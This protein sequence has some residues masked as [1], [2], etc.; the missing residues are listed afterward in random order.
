M[1]VVNI[2][3]TFYSNDFQFA[4]LH[5]GASYAGGLVFD[6]DNSGNGFV[7]AVSD[8]IQSPWFYASSVCAGYSDG[9]Y[10]D[11]YLPSK[12]KLNQMYKNLHLNG[13]GGFTS[14]YFYWS[15]AAYDSN[16]AWVQGFTNDMQ[17][18]SSIQIY[19][20][21]RAIRAFQ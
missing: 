5:Y 13:L 17:Y 2:Y 4:N 14:S 7:A 10:H 8:Q 9:T 3:G 12:V 20:E 16:S 19:Y 1:V 15:S 6:Y 11:W 18:I 21:L